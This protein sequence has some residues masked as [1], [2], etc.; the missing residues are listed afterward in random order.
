MDVK[1]Y[2]GRTYYLFELDVPHM[3]IAATAAGNRLYLMSVSANG[4]DDV[5]SFNTHR[6]TLYLF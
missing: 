4:T 2:N 6:N 5:K 3:L 1:K